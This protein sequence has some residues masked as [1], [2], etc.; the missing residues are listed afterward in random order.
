MLT[1]PPSV[2]ATVKLMASVSSIYMSLSPMGDMTRVRAKI[3]IDMLPILCMFANSSLWTLYGVLVNNW[4]PLVATNAVGMALSGYYLVVIY[5]H[6]GTRRGAAAK[7]TLATLGFVAIAVAYSIYGTR[8]QLHHVA[9]HVGYTGVAVS[10][11]TVASPLSSVGTVFK[12]KS[13]ASLPFKMITAGIACSL[14]WLS[15]GVLI[16]D[17]LVIAPNIVNL[18]LG[19]FQL[20]LCFLYPAAATKTDAELELPTKPSSES[21]NK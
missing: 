20:S 3:P 1:H 21:T 5:T 13:A 18:V 8:L 17:M 10:S 9:T 16:D 14:M 4:F 12:H 15:F 6:A 7:K 2:V 11:L 19:L